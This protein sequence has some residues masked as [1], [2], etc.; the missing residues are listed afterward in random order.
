MRL[1]TF[2]VGFGELPHITYRTFTI[3]PIIASQYYIWW[4]SRGVE[5]EWEQALFRL[6]LSAAAF[7][8]V[9]LAR[10]ELGPAWA[11]SDGL[12]LV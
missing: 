8:F 5:D 11:R 3:V 9:I 2:D 1:F 6:Y 12:C 10:F 4:R 7:L